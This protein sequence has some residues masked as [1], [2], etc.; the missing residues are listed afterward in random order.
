MKVIELFAGIGATSMALKANNISFD[1]VGISEIDKKAIEIYEK[2][3]GK[4]ENF[5]DITKIK[6]LPCC[7]FLHA[8]SPCQSYSKAGKHNGR[9]GESGLIFDFFRLM[10]DYYKRQELPKYISYE[11]VPELKEFF[12]EDYNLLINNLK[13]WGYNVYSEILEAQYFNN[14]TNRRRLFVI[15]IRKDIDRG[16]FVMP[17][18]NTLTKL[19]IIDFLEKDVDKKYDWQQTPIFH[20]SIRGEEK[21]TDTIQKIGWLETPCKHQTQSNKVWNKYG[22]LPTITCSARFWVR[23]REREI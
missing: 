4:V 9:E 23:E 15:G 8:S 5:G 16:N 11:N 17:K 10:E 6:H 7:D 14:P 21:R 13:K 20:S 18:N 12:I 19:R 2:I 3:H 1:V 22:L